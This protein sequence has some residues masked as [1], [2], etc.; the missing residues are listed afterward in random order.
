MNPCQS[1]LKQEATVQQID[2]IHPPAGPPEVK[3][4]HLCA[5]C[6]KQRGIPVPGQIPSYPKVVSMLGSALLGSIQAATQKRD[7]NELACPDCG[8]TLRDFRQTSR[9]GCPR[10]YEIFGAQVEDVLERIH[11]TSEHPV[12]PEEAELVRI[13]AEMAEA[14]RCEDYETAA[15]LRDRIRDLAAQVETTEEFEF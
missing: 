1:C 6:A 10:D 2:V 15:S 8:W 9:F 5:A 3:V 11:G 4:L 14:V 13:K 12:R 7:P